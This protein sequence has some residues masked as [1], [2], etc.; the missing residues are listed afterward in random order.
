VFVV[1][2]P[3]RSHQAFALVSKPAK[4]PPHGLVAD[5]SLPSLPV[6]EATIQEVF[7]SIQ[8]EGLWVGHRQLFI[9][10]AHCHLACAYCDTPMRSAT[11]LA[12]VQTVPGGSLWQ[13]LPNPMTA[14][15]LLSCI[16]GLLQ[17][18]PHHSI[19]LTGGEPLLYPEFT[20]ALF[21]R[22]RALGYLTYLE[23]SG[24]QPK[25]LARVLPVTSMVA[26]DIK[27]ASAT[28]QPTPWE[29]HAEFL[30]LAVAAAPETEVF[31]KLVVNANTPQQ[32]LAQV[33][34]LMQ[35]YLHVPLFIQP[36]SPLTG[37]L[38][39][40]LSS[41]QLLMFQTDLLRQGLQQVRVVP[42]THK[43]LCVD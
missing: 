20:A 42:Q 14:D 35:P 5:V 9:R 16:D 30:R 10:V 17:D 40:M 26:M 41:Q 27:L 4:L 29:A 39:P 13:P 37:G 7:S 3:T 31:V 32:E 25:R 23:S 43:Q 15:T 36:Q 12:Y 1:L 28:L 22:L 8:G 24:T 34:S 11:G 33:A 38:T 6:G 2:S 18:Y 19:S 21:G